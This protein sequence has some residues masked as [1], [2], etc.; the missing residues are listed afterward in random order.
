MSIPWAK[1]GVWL[2]KTFGPVVAQKVVERFSKPK[3]VEVPVEEVKPLVKK[4]GKR[5]R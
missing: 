2:A 3:P 5:D 1:V 4:Y